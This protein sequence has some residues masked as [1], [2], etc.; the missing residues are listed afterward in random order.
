LIE[1]S[2]NVNDFDLAFGRTANGNGI[3]LAKNFKIKTAGTQSNLPSDNA[4]L[5]VLQ[6]NMQRLP[7]NDNASWGVAPKQMGVL[8]SVWSALGFC[9]LLIVGAILLLVFRMVPASEDS[10]Y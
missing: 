3:S 7:L 5:D 1:Y 9:V 6:S 8:A 4:L 2:S 10:D